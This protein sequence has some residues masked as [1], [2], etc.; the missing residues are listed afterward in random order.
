LVLTFFILKTLLL[1]FI[2]RKKPELEPEPEPEPTN[3]FQTLFYFLFP[4][5][6]IE[7][8]QKYV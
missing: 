1:L 8:S 7:N 2:E 4:P 6:N 5:K 3:I